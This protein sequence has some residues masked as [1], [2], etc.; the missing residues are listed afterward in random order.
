M[1]PSGVRLGLFPGSRLADG[2]LLVLSGYRLDRHD[3][4]WSRYDVAG[5]IIGDPLCMEYDEATDTRYIGERGSVDTVQ[6]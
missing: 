2:D 4:R 1:V 6:F 3:A 5:D